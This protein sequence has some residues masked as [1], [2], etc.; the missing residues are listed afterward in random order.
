MGI[1]LLR[2][3]GLVASRLRQQGVIYVFVGLSNTL[4]HYFHDVFDFHVALPAKV[5]P[6][7]LAPLMAHIKDR[8]S[9][10]VNDK[11]IYHGLTDQCQLRAIFSMVSTSA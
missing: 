1:R 2:T 9:F 11:F 3:Q 7:N 8:W 6:A 10:Y 4:F 5:I